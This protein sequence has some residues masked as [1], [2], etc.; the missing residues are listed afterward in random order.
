MKMKL[1]K[2]FLIC[3]KHDIIKNRF[4]KN[5]SIEIYY[6][7][8]NTNLSNYDYPYYIYHNIDK[9]IYDIKNNQPLGI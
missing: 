4:A 3:R 7:S 8:L 2:K 1:Y 9:L 5:N 6:I